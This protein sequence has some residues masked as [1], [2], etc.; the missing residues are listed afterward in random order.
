[1]QGV[2]CWAEIDLSALRHN[3]ECVRGALTAGTELIAVVKADAYG[4][5]LEI[6]AKE[7]LAQGVDVLAVASPREGAQL[8]I[9]APNV[10]ILVL[11]PV[12]PDE[13]DLVLRH[14]LEVIV[15]SLEDLALFET[16]DRPV[17][18]HLKM[19]TGMGRLGAEN[20]ISLGELYTRVRAHP[21]FI[22]AGICTHF[23]AADEDSTLTL[24]QRKRFYQA[25]KAL[26]GLDVSTLLIHADNSAGLDY[27]DASG[28]CNGVR[29]GLALYGYPPSSVERFNH[30]SFK[31]VMS[32]HARVGLVKHL[33]KGST[34]SYGA[35]VRLARDSRL[36][37]LTMGYADGFPVSASNRAQV[38][39][40]GACCPVLGRICMD[41]T[42]VDITDHPGS[43]A[44]GDLA[45][46]M[47]SQGDVS[48]DAEE[49]ARHAGSISW[50][51]LCG[52]S[53]RVPRVAN[54][55]C[56]HTQKSDPTMK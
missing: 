41:L 36:A 40:Q 15:S 48:I 46:W 1:M 10:R 32:V 56:V 12:L 23:A 9:I 31:P 19:D 37:V 49:L 24:E 54:E 7:L 28:P 39:I 27:F 45:T 33:P 11:G 18:L 16:A 2:R 43:V 5:G 26:P 52:V 29:V 44:R 4:H 6:I 53:K 8:R 22:L 14:D 25:M 51:R 17:R 34:V 3:V 21:R 38:L 42:V 20:G 50:E 30:V 13:L 35:T 47:G 55:Y